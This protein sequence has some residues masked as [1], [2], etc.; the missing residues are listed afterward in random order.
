MIGSHDLWLAAAC[1]AHGL[2]IATA[3]IRE[4]GRVPGLT[5]DAWLEHP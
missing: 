3:N 1:L 2:E 5:V 4:F